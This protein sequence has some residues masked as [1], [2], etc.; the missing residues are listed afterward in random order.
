LSA[1]G[2]WLSASGGAR[3]SNGETAL[4]NFQSIT[5]DAKNMSFPDFDK[6]NCRISIDFI[7]KNDNE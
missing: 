6:Q 7:P 5:G 2:T 3:F 1:V 4:H